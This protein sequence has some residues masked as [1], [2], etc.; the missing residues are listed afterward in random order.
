MDEPVLG[1]PLS[2]FS[3]GLW[4]RATNAAPEGHFASPQFVEPGQV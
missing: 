1:E 3:Y 2:A 4:Y